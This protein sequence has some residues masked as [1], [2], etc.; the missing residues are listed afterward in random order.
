MRA[1][2]NF[3]EYVPLFLILLT[4]I[5][6]AHGSDDWLWAVAILF[7]LG[8]LA[9]PFGMQAGKLTTLRIVGIAITWLVL[10]GLA[11]CAIAT[12]YSSLSRPAPI[13]YAEAVRAST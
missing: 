3:A 10:L 9:H 12:A 13:T 2:A 6:L 1:H 8:R 11:A 4:L 5:E 7:V